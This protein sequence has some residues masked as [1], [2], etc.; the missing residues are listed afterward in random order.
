MTQLSAARFEGYYAGLT[1]MARK[2]Y[3]AIPIAEVWSVTQV[4]QEMVRLGFS[5]DLTKT[6]G[7]LRSLL[8]TTLIIEKPPGHYRR[9]AIKPKKAPMATQAIMTVV[10]AAPVSV[11]AELTPPTPEEILSALSTRCMEFATDIDEASIAI[12]KYMA[13]REVDSQ[14]LKQLQ[15]LLK[16]LST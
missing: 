13:A 6:S 4:H 2:V 5:A 15:A 12:K 11:A 8:G 9:S 7:C 3:E 14:K 10:S 1:S 16:G